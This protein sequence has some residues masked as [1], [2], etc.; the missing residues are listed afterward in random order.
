MFQCW[1]SA[2]AFVSAPWHLEKNWLVWCL[3]F[4]LHRRV[5]ISKQFCRVVKNR[6]AAYHL[7][8][9]FCGGS[10]VSDWNRG[11]KLFSSYKF[12]ISIFMLRNFPADV[13]SLHVGSHGHHARSFVRQIWETSERSSIFYGKIDFIIVIKSSCNG[14]CRIPSARSTA[15]RVSAPLLGHCPSHQHHQPKR[16]TR[17]A[18]SEC[19][20]SGGHYAAYVALLAGKRSITVS[21]LRN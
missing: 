19:A 10:L 20:S 14:S 13:R 21:C 5:I 11:W 15:A 4:S 3:E 7:G 8:A 18:H 6:T 17:F 9:N 1:W 12:A 2:W 16:A